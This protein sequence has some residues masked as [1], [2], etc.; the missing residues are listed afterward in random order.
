MAFEPLTCNSFAIDSSSTCALTMVETAAVRESVPEAPSPSIFP[1][2]RSAPSLSM[3]ALPLEE[4]PAT[5]NRSRERRTSSDNVSD[6]LTISVTLPAPMGVALG[7]DAIRLS[8]PLLRNVATVFSALR[9]LLA[10][11]PP[12]NF[13]A[14]ATAIVENG[15]RFAILSPPELS[16]APFSAKS[17]ARLVTRSVPF[18]AS[19]DSGKS[20]L[21]VDIVML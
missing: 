17:G 18:R 1:S 8:R 20:E 16:A 5:V 14:S 13:L 19:N 10:V 3:T 11:A 2:V 9:R 6:A 4:K 15:L 12:D 21:T 7:P